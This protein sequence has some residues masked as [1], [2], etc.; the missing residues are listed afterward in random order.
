MGGKRKGFCG[1]HSLRI[2]GVTP[3]ILASAD[4]ARSHRRAP[5]KSTV[6]STF[7]TSLFHLPISII[8]LIFLQNGQLEA[9]VIKGG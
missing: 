3:H 9:T 7:H 4:F 8:P 6:R 2:A 1:K 5:A